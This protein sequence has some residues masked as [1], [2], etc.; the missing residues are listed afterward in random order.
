MRT[1]SAEPRE[2]RVGGRVDEE[3]DEEA[4]GRVIGI[5]ICYVVLS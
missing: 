4:V 1:S 2:A 5:I 3:E